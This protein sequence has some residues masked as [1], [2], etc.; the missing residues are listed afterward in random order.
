MCYFCDEN[1]ENHD[2]MNGIQTF[3]DG[4]YLVLETTEWDEW[5]DCFRDVHIMVNYCPKCGDKL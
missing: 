5:D 2:Y 4:K 1:H 3:S